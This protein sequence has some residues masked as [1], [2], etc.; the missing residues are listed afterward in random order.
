MR[1]LH[2]IRSSL[3]TSKSTGD[4]ANANPEA[5]AELATAIDQLLDTVGSKFTAMSKDIMN[6]SLSK[7]P[8]E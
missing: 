5:Q 8:L 4:D 3:T 6:Q 2:G 1:N 7:Q